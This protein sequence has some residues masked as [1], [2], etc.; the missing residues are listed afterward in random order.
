MKI[1]LILAV[2]LASFTLYSC[3]QTEE[4]PTVQ[5]LSASQLAERLANDSHFQEAVSI[6]GANALSLNSSY[7]E[8][9]SL[10]HQTLLVQTHG[11]YADF[12]AVVAEGSPE[13]KQVVALAMKPLGESAAPHLVQS[14]EALAGYEYDRESLFE[15]AENA[16][17]IS[18]G[19]LRVS[20]P[21]DDICDEVYQY[22]YFTAFNI[23]YGI[24][25]DWEDA[26]RTAEL[27]ASTAKWGC[28]IGCLSMA[29]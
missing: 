27:S 24:S 26:D 12:G 11:S 9:L 7:F 19:H 8:S 1:K 4:L 15:A 6:L 16:F 14:L 5:K 2:L 22:R 23:A 13:E 29:E 18:V 17:Q 25:G 3:E 28:L 20:N 21:C 10:A